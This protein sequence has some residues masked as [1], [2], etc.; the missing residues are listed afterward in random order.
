ME[1]RRVDI[2]QLFFEHGQGRPFSFKVHSDRDSPFL[3]LMD[4][5]IEESERWLDVECVMYTP[6]IRSLSAIKNRIP[7]L[8]TLVL[9]PVGL[10]HSR[11]NAP[12]GCEDVFKNAP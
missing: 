5:F 11:W 12:P 2:A 9:Y 8:R 3:R 7:L 1:T 10:E 4:V 6:K